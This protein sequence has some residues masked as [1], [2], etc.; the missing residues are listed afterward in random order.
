MSFLEGMCQSQQLFNLFSD[1][2]KIRKS[3]VYSFQKEESKC[4][5]FSYPYSSFFFERDFV[6]DLQFYVGE[7]KMQSRSSLEDD[8]IAPPFE[9]PD[10]L[11]R[12]YALVIGTTDYKKGAPT[13]TNLP[14]GVEDAKSIKEVLEANYGYK[15]EL[16]LDP[17]SDTIIAALKRY[18]YKLQENDQFIFYVA[19]HGEYDPLFFNDG[20][21]VTSS[22]LPRKADPY[23][24]TSLPFSQL[25]NIIDNFRN[26]QILLLID[27]CFGGAFDEKISSGETRSGA[28]NPYLDIPLRAVAF[29]KLELKTRIVLS[30]GSLNK[31]PDGYQGKHSPYAAR[32]LTCLET[33]GGKDG[34]L[35]SIQ[36]FSYVQK[37]PSK[38]LLGELRGNDSG[39]EFFLIP[40]SGN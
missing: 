32:I 25:R 26:K 8:E 35:T 31:V 38:P 13:Y 24:R 23:R 17:H 16:L 36:L 39:G 15:V 27:V 19:G 28:D 34:Y 29:E 4:K 6:K 9:M 30:S 3:A 22:S 37:F 12:Q 33:K 21:L 2:D 5:E 1:D 11:G 20:F 40:K 7:A 18:S 14:N 10:E